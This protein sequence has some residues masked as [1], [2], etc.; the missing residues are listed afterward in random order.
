MLSS[1]PWLYEITPALTQELRNTLAVL[2]PHGALPPD[3][4]QLKAQ[5]DRSGLNYESKVQGLL[6][7]NSPV[8]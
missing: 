1:H 4:A 7:E 5:V 2:S 3:A 8:L 6:M